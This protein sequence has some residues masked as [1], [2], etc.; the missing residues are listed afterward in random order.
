MKASLTIHTT[1][2]HGESLFLSNTA[3]V[4]E[5]CLL[6]GVGCFHKSK[7]VSLR[8]GYNKVPSESDQTLGS[9]VLLFLAA[10]DFF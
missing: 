7:E 4:W 9:R 6:E 10:W 2:S 8:V 3:Q 5:S 1:D